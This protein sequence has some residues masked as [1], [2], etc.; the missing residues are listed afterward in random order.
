MHNELCPMSELPESCFYVKSTGHHLREYYC[1]YCDRDC[2]CA[3]IETV[4]SQQTLRIL[5]FLAKKADQAKGKGLVASEPGLEEARIV[6]NMI[7]D[8]THT[9]IK[10]VAHLIGQ[11]FKDKDE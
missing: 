8:E 7:G 4:Q 10:W 11:E 9:Y 2:E 1:A 5:Q 6:A 3:F